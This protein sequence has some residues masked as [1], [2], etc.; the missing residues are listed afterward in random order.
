MEDYTS[1]SFLGLWKLGLSR[2]DQTGDEELKYPGLLDPAH[3][4]YIRWKE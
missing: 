1:E 4:K 2:C 3:F